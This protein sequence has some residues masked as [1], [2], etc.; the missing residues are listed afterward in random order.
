MTLKHPNIDSEIRIPDDAVLVSRTDAKGLITYVN[1][2]FAEISGYTLSELR[3]KSHNIVRH[4]DVP[5]AIFSDLWDTLKQGQCWHGVVKNR[6]KSGRYYWADAW[7][8]PIFE[9]CNIVGYSSIHRKASPEQVVATTDLYASLHKGGKLKSWWQ[10]QWL[11][12]I[13]SIRTG[14][15]LG[16]V[17]AITA[18]L[19]GTAYSVIK[20][21]QYQS[22]ES[23]LYQANS[24][25]TDNLGKI[26]FLMAENRTQLVMALLHNPKTPSPMQHMDH[27]IGVHLA[28]V[29]ENKAE[30]NRIWKEF[31]RLPIDASVR[32]SAENY[33]QRRLHYVELGLDPIQQALVRE[34]N[35]EQAS[36]LLTGQLVELYRSANESIDL[37]ISELQGSNVAATKA[38]AQR[39]EREIVVMTWAAVAAALIFTLS[40][41]MF[42]RGIMRPLKSSIEN[43]IAIARG[44][45]SRHPDALG[46]G[47]TFALSQAVAITQ[48][49]LH[50]ILD[51]IAQDATVLSGAAARLNIQV[52][53]IADGTDEQHSRV[54]L[55]LVK[56]IAS[57]DDIKNISI[58][59]EE[60]HGR[61][62]LIFDRIC[63]GTQN[64][65]NMDN[66]VRQLTKALQTLSEHP[67]ERDARNII[68]DAISTI[69]YLGAQTNESLSAILELSHSIV[70]QSRDFAVNTRLAAFSADD[71]QHD[72]EVITEFLVDN[73][74]ASNS[75][76][77]ATHQVLEQAGALE[78]LSATFMFS[79]DSLLSG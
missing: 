11:R 15:M 41:M 54:H 3:G 20:I 36:R 68:E 37:L 77:A 1:S 60:L 62:E 78:R 76:W 61:S 67:A 63:I 34:P 4:S 8:S 38:L 66:T 44:D 49:N 6:A 23:R 27:E 52:N 18:C 58:Q 72:I 35:Y 16:I 14:V 75:I 31:I 43:L 59:A 56:M 24:A 32:L 29:S 42:F 47:E 39:I 5:P 19:I 74:Q 50:A 17:S 64:I 73:R 10:S 53:R 30:I 2:Y 51:E 69:A 33:W 21:K 71:L 55:M 9:E 40:G 26:K 57:A 25:A 65:T 13:I 48:C 70:S 79:Q 7:I 28:T 22:E 12:E 46:L 45:L